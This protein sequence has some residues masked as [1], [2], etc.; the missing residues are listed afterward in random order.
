M[1]D[2]NVVENNTPA[3]TTPPQEPEYSP[4]EQ[5]AMAQGWVPEDQWNGKGK[6]RDAEEFLE[7]G[8]L[9]A[10]IDEQSR[11]IKSLKSQQDAVNQH[12]ELVRKNEYN[13]AL[14]DFKRERKLALAEGDAD[15]VVEVEERMEAFKQQV[16]A[17]EAAI[18]QQSQVAQASAHQDPVLQ[19]WMSRNPWYSTD[20]AMKIYADQIGHELASAGLTNPQEIL[21]EVERR[22]KKEFAERFNNP[23]RTKPG[24]V[25]S[26]TG[27]KGSRGR[28]DSFVLTE[29]ENR[30]INKMIRA[31]API[32]REQYIKDL[33]AEYRGTGRPGA[34]E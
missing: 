5:Q 24:A 27:T 14:A 12:L 1:A 7:R 10:K 17:R 9:F 21:L 32:T 13:R 28:A 33:K 22:T 34:D 26:G 16:A 31:G 15:A 4:I 6:W 25:E 30:V 18:A 19:V 3:E 20:K 11:H 29:D 23:N 8:E 2:E